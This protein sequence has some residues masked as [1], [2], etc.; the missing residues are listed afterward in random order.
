MRLLT[1]V[2][3]LGVVFGFFMFIIANLNFYGVLDVEV[4]RQNQVFVGEGEICASNYVRF[5]CEEGLICATPDGRT[6]FDTNL[7]SARCQRPG[8]I[9]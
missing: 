3:I 7:E 8:N 6:Q 4:K 1:L 5:N 9:S 2:I